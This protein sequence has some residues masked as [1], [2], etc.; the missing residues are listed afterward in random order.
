MNENGI[1]TERLSHAQ[2]MYEVNGYA[3]IS[4]VYTKQEVDILRANAIMT[5]RT[6]H[7]SNIQMKGNFPA[8]L[9]WPK[10]YSIAMREIIYDPR[11]VSLVKWFLGP[12]V[13]QLN[14]Q[15]YFRLPGDGDEFAWHQ[16]ICFRTPK[17]EFDG[18]ETSYLQTAIIVDPMSKSNGGIEFI[19]FS[20]KHGIQELVPRD[21]TERGL[22]KFSRDNRQ[23]VIPCAN[24]GDILIWSVMTVHGSEPNNSLLSRMYYMNGFAAN[25]AVQTKEDFPRYLREGR[26]V[27]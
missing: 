15:F 4:G 5:L 16:D 27:P 12:D 11:M 21:N 19:P 25:K 26:I 9:F 13:R 18:I 17:E 23:G 1:A 22:R 6:A 2:D 7:Q 3:I 20:H 14:N 10:D 8:L 24:P